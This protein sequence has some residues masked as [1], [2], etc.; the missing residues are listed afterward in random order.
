MNTLRL[1]LAKYIAPNGTK[2]LTEQE[3]NDSLHVAQHSTVSEIMEY[4]R[5][6]NGA[7][8]WGDCVWKYICRKYD[9]TK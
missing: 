9:E 2:V 4:V 5:L 7:E 8:H 3:F 6:L 1:K